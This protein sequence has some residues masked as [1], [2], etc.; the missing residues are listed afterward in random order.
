MLWCTTIVDF[1]QFH[2]AVSSGYQFEICGRKFPHSTIYATANT[3]TH[4][5]LRLC[6]HSQI[7]PISSKDVI[8]DDSLPSD[9]T[10]V[11]GGSL[12]TTPP[13]PLQITQFSQ[14][15]ELAFFG[16]LQ[17]ISATMTSQR[18]LVFHT[19]PTLNCFWSGA[20]W[21]WCSFIYH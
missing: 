1:I 10:G 3:K 7:F 21:R 14:R 13:P 2:R 12:I 4:L 16:L 18:P 5:M 20:Y 11:G 6:V 9:N 17:P 8:A 19:R 15:S